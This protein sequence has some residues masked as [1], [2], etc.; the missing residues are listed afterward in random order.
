MKHC[1][2]CGR[3]L[4]EE[5]FFFTDCGKK[6]EEASKEIGGA[7]FLFVGKSRNIVMALL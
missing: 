4:P 1:T 5:T 6:V 7:F 3:E 2:K